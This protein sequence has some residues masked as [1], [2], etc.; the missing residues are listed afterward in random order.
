MNVIDH[1]RDMLRYERWANDR[2]LQSLESIPGEERHGRVYE[3]AMS[4]LA[5][6]ALARKVWLWRIQGTPYENPPDW[7]PVTSLQDQRRLCDEAD[8]AWEQF[9]DSLD[10]AALDREVR[11][12]AS[13]GDRFSSTL[14][15][16]LVHVFNHS[17]Y[18]RGQIARLVTECG[19]QRVPTDYIA[20]GRVSL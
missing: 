12:A 5:H 19:G 3:R 7:F 9:I 11:Y 17:T 13:N 15:E 1:Y 8:R 16:I 6:N 14:R 4:L 18:H 20:M 10:D 2:V